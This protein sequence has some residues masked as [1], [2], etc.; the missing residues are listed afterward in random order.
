MQIITQEENVKRIPP[1]EDIKWIIT[2]D[3]RRVPIS[4]RY[5]DILK[6]IHI[7]GIGVDSLKQLITYFQKVDRDIA[8]GYTGFVE[9]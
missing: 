6:A 1:G 4:V 7:R 5:D 8:A 9:E 2:L 3:A